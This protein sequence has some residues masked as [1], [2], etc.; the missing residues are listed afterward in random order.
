MNNIFIEK[1]KSLYNLILE[2]IDIMFK[3]T[4]INRY[5]SDLNIGINDS[6]GEYYY[7]LV[8]KSKNSGVVYTPVEISEYIIRST[9]K[10]D[11]VVKNPFIKIL[12][13]ASGCGN[14]IIPCYRNLKRIYLDNLDTINQMHNIRLTLEN[15]DKHII[16]NNIFG[17]DIDE[18]SIKVLLIDL[19]LEAKTIL[20]DNFIVGDFL[21]DNSPIVFDVIIGNPPYVGHKSIDREYCRRLKENYSNIYKDKG[22]L[23]Y[24]FFKRSIEKTTKRGK[25]SFITSR[26]FIEA[27]SGENLRKLLLADININSVVDFY[28]IRPFKDAGIDPII[29]FLEKGNNINEID[30]IK[31]LGSNKELSE[32]FY[33]SVFMNQEH[34]YRCFKLTKQDLKDTWMLIDRVER[35]IINKINAKCNSTLGDICDSYQGIITGCDKA[36]IVDKEI[37]ENMEIETELLRPWIKNSNIK[38]FKVEKNNKFIIYSDFIDEQDKYKKSIEYIEKFKD[39]LSN[40]RECIKGIR[41]WY[42]LQ[43]GRNPDLFEKEKIIFPYKADSNKF[44][45]DKGSYFSADV[46]CLLPKSTMNVSNSYLVSILN[47]KLYEF[48]FKCYGKKL[49]GKLYDYYPNTIMKLPIA[50]DIQIIDDF[51]VSIYNYFNLSYEQIEIIEEKLKSN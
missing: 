36:F 49:G 31:P 12:D 35:E 20:K 18:I 43:W 22:D 46:Y 29:I 39:K 4:A 7:K 44:A 16:N 41:K 34:A 6:F 17:Y 32:N 33:N 25:I 14:I 26:Y 1:I 45:V 19:F 50:L 30:I 27:P 10:E 42:Q 37:I 24:C 2:P 15:I 40:R 9:I 28:G 38:Q 48:Y 21:F 23:S 13:P 47:S 51:N 11:D 8:E 5:K 3:L